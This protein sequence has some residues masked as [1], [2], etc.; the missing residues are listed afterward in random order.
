MVDLG[1]GYG[2]RTA[3]LLTRMDE[4]LGNAVGNA[5]EVQESVETLRG[6]GPADL[7]EVTIALAQEMLAL[8]GVD[9]D[10]AAVLQSGGA[11]GRYEAMIRAQGGDPSAEL[12]QAPHRDVVRAGTSG[13]LRRLDALGVGLAAWRLGAGRS[14]Q[15]E[16]VSAGAGIV[17]RAKPGEV[18]EAGQILLELH[19]DDAG[20]FARAH[21]ALAGAIEVGTQP[22]VRAAL[23]VDVIRPA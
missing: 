17:C 11:L 14:K 22:P 6:N 16:A 10:P 20:R 13:Y 5:L 18:V 23:V 2:L 21:D 3:A 7:V 12:A 4:P 19:A 1:S 8:A 9:A 15:G